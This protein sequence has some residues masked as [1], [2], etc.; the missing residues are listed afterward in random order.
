M[1]PC[2][3]QT[4]ACKPSSTPE[5]QAPLKAQSGRA[6]WVSSPR[7]PVRTGENPT[8]FPELEQGPCRQQP[9]A[10]TE[11]QPLQGKGLGLLRAQVPSPLAEGRPGN[12][13]TLNLQG[14][15]EA[16]QDHP[17]KGVFSYQRRLRG[18]PHCEMKSLPDS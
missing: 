17:G 18:K 10:A 9:P 11:V 13:Q 16:Q 1:L 3:H 4:S 15:E 14:R 8:H 6:G 7:T 2:G 5:A 12:F